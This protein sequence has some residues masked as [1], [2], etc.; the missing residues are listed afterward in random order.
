[1]W[2]RCMCKVCRYLAYIFQIAVSKLWIL[3]RVDVNLI[4]LFLNIYI[5]LMKIV[6][7]LIL[8]YLAQIVKLKKIQ[9]QCYKN[10]CFKYDIFNIGKNMKDIKIQY[11][12]VTINYEIYMI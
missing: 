1:V 6:E 10:K 7:E 4:I 9:K 12:S 5:F 8:Y 2:T 11:K 3:V